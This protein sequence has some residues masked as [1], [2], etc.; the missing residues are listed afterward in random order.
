MVNK[1]Y[2]NDIKI[3]SYKYIQNDILNITVEN[4]ENLMFKIL[5]QNRD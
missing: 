1:R 2:D 3:K 4:Q 5:S